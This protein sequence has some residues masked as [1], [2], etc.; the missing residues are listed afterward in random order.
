MYDS[1]MNAF[2]RKI[3][4]GI[5]GV[6]YFGMGTCLSKTQ[7]VGKGLV[8]QKWKN[9]VSNTVRNFFFVLRVL[10]NLILIK[11]PTDIRISI[12]LCL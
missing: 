1:V 8:S 6:R 12:A 7:G 10:K 11:I 2:Q 4:H 9:T 3:T 5:Y